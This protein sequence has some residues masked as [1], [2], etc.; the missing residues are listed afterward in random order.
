[1]SDIELGYMPATEMAGRIKAGELSPVEAT[2]AALARIERLQ[3]DFNAFITVCG[4]QAMD[5]ARAAEADVT[6][7]KALGPLH[8]V[9]FSVKDL[10]NTEGVLTTFG[11][12]AFEANVPAAD[13]V[14]IA[15]LRAAGAI[16]VGK[17]TT[18][19]FGH[20]PM[21]EAPLFGRTLNPWD[22]S[23]TSGGSSGGAGVAAA[24]GMGPLHVGTD[25]GGS[26]RI[27]A[28]ACGI[29]GMK[30]TLG[31]VPHDMTPDCFDLLSYIGPMTRTVADNGL[32]LEI[33]SGPHPSDVHS[34]G[35]ETPDL[36]GAA[37]G[38]GD[39]KGKR[40]GWR[41]FLGNEVIDTETR[42]LVE[43][44]LPAF[45]DLGAELIP[46]DGP[47]E[48]TLPHWAPLTYTMWSAR[49]GQM[50]ADLGEKM[51]DTLRFWMEEAKDITGAD[52]QNALAARTRVYREVEGWFEDVDLVV[53]PTLARPAIPADH[54]PR[55]PI[56]IEGKAV[57]VPRAAWY[58]YTHPFNLS[59][60]PAITVPAGW[61]E[62]GLPVGLQIVG[63]WLADAA[64]LH[65]A[66]CFERARPWADKRPAAAE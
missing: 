7:G 33:M 51:S 62:A 13:A 16:L 32:M 27:P 19:E 8:G 58:P 46:S 49:F 44:A 54:D 43:A 52:V 35:R 4:D 14:C 10:V 47:F 42:A 57:D 34:L 9:P 21:T 15:R 50:A 36:A 66:A 60:H 11:S 53:M 3:P 6:A 63:P 20:K 22:P 24:A 64:V 1:M 2:A 48:P 45:A 37:R 40:I 55:Q 65:A 12:Q 28:A 17:T 39:L 26:T 18:P 41:L 5:A 56:E 61:T 59:G 30:Q 25:G 38:D 31:R 29:V 23:A